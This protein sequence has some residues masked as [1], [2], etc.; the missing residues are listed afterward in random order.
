MDTYATKLCII[1]IKVFVK[2]ME[3]AWNNTMVTL[4]LVKMVTLEND[5]VYCR[6]IICLVLATLFVKTC[7]STTLHEKVIGAIV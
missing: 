7:C 6:V 5:A 1:A 3:N 4:V 2:I